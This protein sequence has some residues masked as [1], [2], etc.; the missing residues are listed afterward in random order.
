MLV[1]ASKL[2]GGSKPISYIRV[3]DETIFRPNGLQ[4]ENP[5]THS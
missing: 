4:K 1:W 3:E 2:V 5:T